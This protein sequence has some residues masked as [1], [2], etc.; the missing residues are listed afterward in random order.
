MNENSEEPY[1]P[2][3]LI[4]LGDFKCGKTSLITQFVDQLFKKSNIT[5][6]GIDRK[7]KYMEACQKRVKL[8]INDTPGQERL[9]AI[10]YNYISRV[11]GVIL[12]YDCTSYSS[13]EGVE[14]WMHQIKQRLRPEDTA[15]VLAG[16]KVD[17]EDKSVPR[18]EG[19]AVADFYKIMFY[20]TSAL[21]GE[22]VN[23]VFSSL[24]EE[25]L[26]K[27]EIKPINPSADRSKEPNSSLKLTDTR[28]RH[29]MKGKGKEKGE[30]KKCCD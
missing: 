7:I 25:V 20:E 6:L 24:V 3:E 13:L 14:N 19:Q 23:Q 26:R 22:N 18:E 4:I 10:A 29:S 21:T 8:N 2:V 12:L 9:K 17:R 11:D 5:T 16:N 27:K 1:Y 15:I 30:K 28:Q